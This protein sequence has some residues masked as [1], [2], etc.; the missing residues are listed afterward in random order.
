LLWFSRA[1][2]TWV[3]LRHGDGAAATLVAQRPLR[4]WPP[5][6]RVR[7]V[8][9]GDGGAGGEGWQDVRPQSRLGEALRG[10]GPG[11][12]LADAFAVHDP[13]RPARC[14]LAAHADAEAGPA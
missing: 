8:F 13:R 1:Y 6:L 14:R 9:A 4:G 3:L 5:R 7:Y 2:R 11:A 12:P 10:A